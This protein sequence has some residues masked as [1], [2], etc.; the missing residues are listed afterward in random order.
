MGSH[1]FFFNYRDGVYRDYA[2]LF[3]GG[4][5]SEY[6]EDE[7]DLDPISYEEKQI[8]DFNKNWMWYD[9]VA[10]EADDDIIRMESIWEMSLK[11]LL[12]HLSYKISKIKTKRN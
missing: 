2:G 8:E 3:S 5:E 6:E 12:N 1:S 10:R 11:S 9:I 4:G 7:E